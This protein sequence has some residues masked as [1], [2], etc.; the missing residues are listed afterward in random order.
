[1]PTEVMLV[2]EC[3]KLK[4]ECWNLQTLL[5]AGGSILIEAWLKRVGRDY[6]GPTD[7]SGA[8]EVQEE[9]HHWYQ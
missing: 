7:G 9:Y 1:M 4:C 2:R 3:F 5:E 8:Q 6:E